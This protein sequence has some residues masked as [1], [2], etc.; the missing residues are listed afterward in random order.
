MQRD[1]VLEATLV[2]KY[3]VMAPLLNERTRRLWAAAESVAIGFG[4][5]AVVSAAT[6]LARKTI[7]D[8]RLELTQTVTVTDPDTANE[9]VS[10]T[11]SA[12]STDTDYD[13][14][15][16]AGVTVTVTDNDTAL[17]VTV[18]PGDAQLVVEWTA[19]DT[20]TGYTVQWKSDSGATRVTVTSGS[21]TSYTISGLTNDT[22]YM[23]RVIATRTGA[24]DGPSSEVTGTPEPPLPAQQQ[25]A[26]AP[27]ATRFVSV[28]PEH[29][30]ATEFWLEL[31][32]D[33][34]VAQGSRRHIR[35]LLEATG[36][37]VTRLRRKDGRLDHWEVRVEPS[38]HGAI[39]PPPMVVPVLMRELHSY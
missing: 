1:T 35:A 10:L 32:F 23:V 38:S 14:I 29:D 22:E 3:V 13:G 2:A 20:A 8:G 33:A 31:T 30:G 18:T 25:A 27:L 12:T 16:I 36:G 7:R 37:T 28:P 34:P 6:G 17:E 21:T 39:D 19:V 5:D 26:L 15:T 4:G 11:H 9:T 24:S